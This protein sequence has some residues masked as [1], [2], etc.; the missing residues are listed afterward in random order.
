[1]EM[2]IENQS[3]CSPMAQG[4]GSIC[5]W[6]ECEGSAKTESHEQGEDSATCFDDLSSSMELRFS[7]CMGPLVLEKLL[8]PMC[9]QSMQDIFLLRSTRGMRITRPLTTLFK[10]SANSDERTASALKIR[11]TKCLCV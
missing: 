3:I 2:M 4:M 11:K 6:E 9:S 8:W 1:M 7:C 5:V 10:F